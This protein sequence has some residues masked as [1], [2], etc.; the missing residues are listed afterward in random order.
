M[1]RSID[2][3]H[4]ERPTTPQRPATAGGTIDEVTFEVTFRQPSLGFRVMNDAERGVIVVK[5]TIKPHQPKADE[6]GEA[7]GEA[8]GAP[9][10]TPGGLK[11]RGDFLDRR[12][13]PGLIVWAVNGAPLGWVSHHKVLAEKIR[14]LGRP[15]RLTF[16]RDVGGEEAAETPS[17]A[18]LDPAEP[19]EAAVAEEAAP[20]PAEP[21]PAP[22]D[23]AAVAAAFVQAAVA[24][25][26]EAA[27]SR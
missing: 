16:K 14:G 21:D 1:I 11:D 17:P 7:P 15:L 12:I 25:A 22:A 23:A 13:E 20:S 4:F 19:V 8:P 2:V 10:T 18:E 24:A 9:P 3:S 6:R 27:A 26:V 5:D